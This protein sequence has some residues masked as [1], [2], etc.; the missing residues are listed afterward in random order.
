MDTLLWLVVEVVVLSFG[1]GLATTIVARRRRRDRRAREQMAQW[2]SDT[3]DDVS[4][5]VTLRSVDPDA[6]MDYWTQL[7]STISSGPYLTKES[8]DI[9]VTKEVNDVRE[10][11]EKIESRFPEGGDLDKYATINDALLAERVGKL[12]EQVTNLEKRLLTR[13]DVVQVV[14]AVLAGAVFVAGAAYGALKALGVAS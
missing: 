10:R 12:A 11:L 1:L 9:R 4:K 13:W 7:A 14:S 5:G 2:A 3:A 8:I 6:A